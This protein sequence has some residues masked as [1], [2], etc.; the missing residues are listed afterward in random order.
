MVRNVSYEVDMDGASRNGQPC[1]L[2]VAPAGLIP[3]R[4]AYA[5]QHSLTEHHNTGLGGLPVELNC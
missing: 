1:S 5:C 4:H 2:Q 3:L